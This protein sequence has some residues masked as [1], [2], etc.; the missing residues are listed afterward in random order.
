MSVFNL[1]I[2]KDSMILTLAASSHSSQMACIHVIVSQASVY[3]FLD[4]IFWAFIFHPSSTSLLS[5]HVSSS[6]PPSDLALSS[7]S[8]RFFKSC[9]I[10]SQHPL[11]SSVSQ[12]VEVE[13]PLI[14]DCPEESLKKTGKLYA[15]CRP[16]MALDVEYILCAADQ[17]QHSNWR[18]DLPKPPIG[19]GGSYQADRKDLR[20]TLLWSIEDGWRVPFCEVSVKYLSF[21]GRHM[22]V[23]KN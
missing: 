3:V 18:V 14:Y 19:E 17:E 10:F 6:E 11:K 12:I 20:P 5:E 16:T 7:A 23:A 15:N 8:W 9:S 21:V 4:F 1:S 22:E 2:F 13:V